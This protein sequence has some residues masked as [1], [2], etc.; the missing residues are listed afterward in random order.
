VRKKA[1]D[2]LTRITSPPAGP[3]LRTPSPIPRTPPDP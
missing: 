2:A 3:D 1:A